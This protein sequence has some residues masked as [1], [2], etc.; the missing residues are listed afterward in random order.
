MSR[1]CA[2]RPRGARGGRRRGRSRRGRDRRARGARRASRSAPDSSKSRRSGARS[3]RMVG[4]MSTWAPA[5]RHAPRLAAD[6]A[7]ASSTVTTTPAARQ[8]RRARE[9]GQPRADHD[10]AVHCERPLARATTAC[11]SRA[12]AAT[13]SGRPRENARRVVAAN[14]STA[15]R[16]PARSGAGPR[17]ERRLGD[18]LG[19]HHLHEPRP[20]PARAKAARATARQRA[21]PA[22]PPGASSSLIQTWP[23]SRRRA[24][25]RAMREIAAPDTGREPVLAAVDP[26][27]GLL[28]GVD[29][30]DGEDRPLD[31]LVRH[32]HAGRHVDQE[33]RGRASTG[34][35]RAVRTASATSAARA[36]RAGRLARYGRCA[37]D[38]GPR[39]L[40]EGGQDGA[41]DER[42]LN[43][44][45]VAA[46]VVELAPHDAGGREVEIGVGQHDGDVPAGQ[47]E[48]GGAPALGLQPV[49]LE[50]RR[51]AARE[52]E[53]VHAGLDDRARGRRAA[54]HDLQQC[55]REA[56]AMEECGRTQRQG[57]ARRRGL[58]H[59]RVAREQRGRDL[60]QGEEQERVARRDDADH[61]VGLPVEAVSS[62]AEVPL[63]AGAPQ[64]VGGQAR[65]AAPREPAQ[66]IERRH[67]LAGPDLGERAV[68]GGGN[69]A[70][71]R[72][73]VCGESPGGILDHGRALRD[74]DVRPPRLRRPSGAHLRH[75]ARRKNASGDLCVHP[76]TRSA[77]PD[78]RSCR[79]RRL[80][81]ALPL[82]APSAL[83][84]RAAATPR[85][86]GA[87]SR[88]SP[89]AVAGSRADGRA[90]QAARTAA[91]RPRNPR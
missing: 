53:L 26:G 52:E 32:A 85:S 69:R 3:V 39:A 37:L 76:A 79:C 74:G 27:D 42:E 20:P 68:R 70:R 14:I 40:D 8:R 72:R 56:S 63:K 73:R 46:R 34:H 77:R 61:P 82:L 38:R 80:E 89:P 51:R 23:T 7:C 36:Q 88:R 18:D 17:A 24:R 41:L 59:D 6:S 55:G 48:H 54:R 30:G 15:A 57:R 64:P 44:D 67:D 25:R 1:P 58:P 29:G 33:R 19:L 4:P 83:S 49:Q 21:P 22:A 60:R 10:H 16:T 66:R 90:R 81:R 91:R 65:G 12:A 71:E 86:G 43:G 31:F 87:G 5:P 35:A 47:L 50:A 2:W 13:R 45:A 11:S 84:A 75:D 62:R 78:V 28:L 9:A